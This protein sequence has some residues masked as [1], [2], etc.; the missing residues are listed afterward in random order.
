MQ[1]MAIYTLLFLF[2]SLNTAYPLEGETWKVYTD[3]PFDEEEAVRRQ[4]ETADA[5]KIPLQRRIEL[6]EGVKM[7]LILIPAG[8]FVMG[9]SKG[10]KDKCADE[11]PAHRVTITRP[12]YMGKYEVS[13]EEWQAVMGENPARYKGEGKPIENISWQQCQKFL[14]KLNALVPDARFRLPTEAQ[15]EYACRT[16]TETPFSY[17]NDLDYE[18]LKEYAVYGRKFKSVSETEDTTEPVGK[19]KPNPWGL[20]DM[21]GNVWEWCHDWYNKDYYKRSPRDD[22]QGPEAGRWKVLRG[23]SWM[24]KPEVCRSAFRDFLDPTYPVDFNG[25]LRIVRDVPAGDKK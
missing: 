14:E 7:A 23:G 19:K 1:R 3:W 13:Q 8:Q 6:A 5:M 20:Y 21:H 2:I 24:S 15:W 11:M 16:G 10:Q 9:S 18:A 22:P 25:G 17:G 4:K 12:F